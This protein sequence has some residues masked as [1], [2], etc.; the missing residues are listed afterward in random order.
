MQSVLG[1]KSARPGTFHPTVHGADFGL[2][3]T[4][5]TLRPV[6]T[7]SGR[8][9]PFACPPGWASGPAEVVEALLVDADVVPGLVDDGDGDLLAQLVEVGAHARQ[10]AAE[11]HDPVR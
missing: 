4:D 11:D 1:A 7:G 6:P 8:V 10:R 3:R 9:P 5:R 2:S